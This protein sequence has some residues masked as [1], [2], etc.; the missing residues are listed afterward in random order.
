MYVNISHLYETIVTQSNIWYQLGAALLIILIALLVRG[1][2]A[3]VIFKIIIKLTHKTKTELD[4][5][6]VIAFEEPLKF[7]IL[8]AGIYL[9]I[10]FLPLGPAAELF[11]EQLARS[12]VIVALVWGFYNL[13][14]GESFTRISEKY[15]IDEIL[16]IFLTKVMRFI[17]IALSIT[18][19]AQEWN[20][21]VTGFIAGLG[22]GGLAFA[23]AAQDTVSN[24]FGGVV[25][26]LDKPFGIGDWIMT[27]NVEGTVEVMS[28]RST[29][30]RNFEKALVTVPN[31]SIVNNP[32]TNWTRMQKRRVSFHLGVT[33]GTPRAK[34][35]S[36]IDKIKTMIEKHPAVHPT[37]IFVRFD[38]FKESSLD[39]FIYFYTKTTN[40]GEWME[41]KENINYRILEILEDE[42]VS[43]AF[44][45]RS[46]YFEN[47][48]QSEEK[49]F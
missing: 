14:G 1:I 30:V 9:G 15:S 22:L 20:Y 36:S 13:V 33:Y 10:S 11:F 32:I 45:S 17:I 46:V 16:A 43:V 42:G 48:V 26:I 29:K 21:N 7:L 3:K 44:P 4:R 8:L 49:A 35:Q 6:I 40:W 18:I 24:L 5:A 27:P 28:F 25:I 31:S 39:I 34:M 23:L 37:T 2:F 47:K 12:L 19:I 38:Q 41:A